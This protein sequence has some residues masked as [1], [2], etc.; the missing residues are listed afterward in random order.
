[1]RCLRLTSRRYRARNKQCVINNSSEST[2]GQLVGR[3][4]EVQVV[5][6]S[7]NEAADSTVRRQGARATFA[8]SEIFALAR[9]VSQDQLT[10]DNDWTWLYHSY[11]NNAVA[12]AL[13]QAAHRVQARL[14]EALAGVGLSIAKFETLSILV[15][16]DRP[17]SLSE[18]AAKLVCVRSNVTQLVDRLE[19]EGLVKR[20]DDPSDRRA[21]RAEVTALGRKRQAAGHPVVNAVLQDV[22]NKLAVVDSRKL[23]RAL[24]A[25]Q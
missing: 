22:A 17:I 14:E 19:T 5:N 1:M 15:S 20:A 12:A 11:M 4:V 24:D 8:E 7:E 9:S 10:L 2:P 25:I 16:R 3:T 23:K 18:L 21:V 13:V 6:V